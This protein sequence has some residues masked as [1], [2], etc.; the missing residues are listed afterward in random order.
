MNWLL[1][2][3]L[4]Q[5]ACDLN[6]C[7]APRASCSAQAPFLLPRRDTHTS[8]R[9]L[10]LRTRTQQM[11][12]VVV[13]LGPNLPA[14]GLLK[15]KLRGAPHHI[16]YSIFPRSPVVW[17]P[18]TMCCATAANGLA[19]CN[20]SGARVADTLCPLCEAGGCSW[21]EGSDSGPSFWG[22]QPLPGR[23]SFCQ[24]ISGRPVPQRQMR[25]PTCQLLL[26]ALV[27][28]SFILFCF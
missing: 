3:R 15:S 14:S 5:C 8:R 7:P 27:G 10:L 1:R 20:A 25:K 21:E 24:I 13:K 6:S 28:F 18:L 4:A 2:Q 26:H 9:H 16:R 19:G 17:S 11:Q 23:R 12:G 22:A